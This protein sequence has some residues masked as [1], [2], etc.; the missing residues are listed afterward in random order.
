M[1]AEWSYALQQA[2]SPA[3]RADF[4]GLCIMVFKRGVYVDC[5][6]RYIGHIDYLRASV[7]ALTF[8]VEP[9]GSIADN[10][11]VAPK[12]HFAFEDGSIR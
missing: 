4:F 3:E 1:C 7:K 10:F 6:D 11:I 9:Y 12:G 2:K 8:F 5:A